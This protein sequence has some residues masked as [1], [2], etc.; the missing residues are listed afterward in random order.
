MQ[1][2]EDEPHYL[3][4]SGQDIF[5]TPSHLFRYI[6]DDNGVC[7][8]ISY[9][10]AQAY[11]KKDLTLLRLIKRMQYTPRDLL[12]REIESLICKGMLRERFESEI[13][14]EVV[15]HKIEVN[16]YIDKQISQEYEEIAELL[17][18]KNL[19]PLTAAE[20][21]TIAAMLE[22]VS[23][24]QFSD[25]YQELLG[26]DK[27]EKDGRFL[28]F[29]KMTVFIQYENKWSHN[30]EEPDNDIQLFDTLGGCYSQYE[31]GEFFRLMQAWIDKEL[32][33]QRVALVLANKNHAV[34]VGYDA[35]DKAWTYLDP[36]ELGDEWDEYVVTDYTELA[37]QV[38]TGFTEI[39]YSVFCTKMYINQ[40]DYNDEL[41]KSFDELKKTNEWLDM[42]TVMKGKLGNGTANGLWL[43]LAIELRDEKSIKDIV[44][45]SDEKDILRSLGEA[46][47]IYNR[48]YICLFLEKITSFQLCEDRGAA[49]IEE[50]VN[51]KDVEVI[52]A[53]LARGAVSHKL[54]PHTA[55]IDM[56][57][58][59]MNAIFDGGEFK[60]NFSLL[61]EK[62][63][64]HTLLTA[65]KDYFNGVPADV[66]VTNLIC[67]IGMIQADIQQHH[68]TQGSYA[69]SLFGKNYNFTVNELDLKIQTVLDQV[70][71]S[72]PNLSSTNR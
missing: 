3:P 63:M 61:I 5:I 2:R 60:D 38:F 35:A 33:D 23:I 25:E 51:H 12:Q 52:I 9:L 21:T 20:A 46:F 29:D 59:K 19:D 31:A 36:N 69:F 71:Q 1:T 58:L 6:T 50:A 44:L 67:E 65:Y 42:H 37:K 56:L 30:Q 55:V 49:F 53:L 15:N 48:E 18:E 47:D 70:I 54:N 26:V 7:M 24:I 32:P 62:Q 43:S 28:N 39:Y 17:K 27:S 10:L 68:N 40:V 41:R 34:M 8:G 4:L 64:H 22:S 66:C 14:A 57:W 13:K 16:D 72:S 45:L 11:L